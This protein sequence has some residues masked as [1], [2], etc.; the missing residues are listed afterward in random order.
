MTLSLNNSTVS[1]F[2]F[3]LCLNFY[4]LAQCVVTKDI[5]E[6]GDELWYEVL[7]N[8]EDGS[9]QKLTRVDLKVGD[10]V[11]LQTTIHAGECYKWLDDCILLESR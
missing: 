3:Y 8:P 1:K 6:Y 5:L 4:D 7:V 11:D 9:G 10:S 2:S